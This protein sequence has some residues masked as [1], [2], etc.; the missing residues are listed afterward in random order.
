MRDK[1]GLEG[2]LELA[3]VDCDNSVDLGLIFLFNFLVGY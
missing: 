3:G 1:L 2:I